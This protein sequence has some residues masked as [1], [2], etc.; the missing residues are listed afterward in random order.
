[1]MTR[2]Y[3]AILAL[4]CLGNLR[5]CPVLR[6]IFLSMAPCPGRTS[7]KNQAFRKQRFVHIFRNGT[8]LSMSRTG[9][10]E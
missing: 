8:A 3:C 6:P 10:G 7:S 9:G 4:R 1:M 2:R 5:T